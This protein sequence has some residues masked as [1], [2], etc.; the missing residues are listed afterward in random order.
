M[1]KLKSFINHKNK[2]VIDA[3]DITLNSRNE[4]AIEVLRS[5]GADIENKINDESRLLHAVKEGDI[6][7]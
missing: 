5:Y 3:L 4:E 7:R 6:K 2:A 1:N